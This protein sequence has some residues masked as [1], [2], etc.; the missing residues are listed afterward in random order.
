FH[1]FPR[2]R[3]NVSAVGEFWVGHNGRRVRVHQHHFKAFLLEG[4]ARLRAGVVEL[5]GLP[6]D[7]RARADYEDLLYVISA[8]HGSGKFPWF[9]RYLSLGQLALS[10]RFPSPEQ[11]RW[12]RRLGRPEKH[13]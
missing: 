1:V 12:L 7:D 10:R 6:D 3:F 8:R 11:L 5:G 2:E 13:S 9:G 4:L